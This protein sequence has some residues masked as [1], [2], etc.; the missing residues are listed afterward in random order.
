MSRTLAFPPYL[1]PRA[2]H[3]SSLTILSLLAGMRKA[4]Q[5]EQGKA[6]L[7][8][9][10]RQLER[11]NK[12]LERQ[13]NEWKMK[14]EAIEKR[15]A[16]RREAELKEH[17]EETTYLEDQGTYYTTRSYATCTCIHLFLWGWTRVQPGTLHLSFWGVGGSGW[18]VVVLSRA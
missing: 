3:G 13:V 10:V 8:A 17:R 6:E 11:E 2:L 18:M 4:L 5:T 15:E 9:R 14:C 16:E 7:E 12:E 1:P